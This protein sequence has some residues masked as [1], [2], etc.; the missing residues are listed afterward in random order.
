MWSKGTGDF[1]KDTLGCA[2]ASRSHSAVS[3]MV[4]FAAQMDPSNGKSELVDG[5]QSH[6][7]SPAC[8]ILINAAA[9]YVVECDDLQKS[10]HRGK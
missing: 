6:T 9:S 10:K 5:S 8:A 3:A 7:T 4:R 1:F 2:M